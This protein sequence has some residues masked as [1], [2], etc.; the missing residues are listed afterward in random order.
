MNANDFKGGRI[1]SRH[2]LRALSLAALL[3]LAASSAWA[4]SD[5]RKGTGGA[6]ELLL[7]VGPR[8]SAL[9]S[10]ITSDVTGVDAIFWN[11]AGLAGLEGSEALF[12]HTQYIADMKVNYAAVAARAGGLGVIGFNAKVLS[13]GEIIVTTEE[14][15][16][17][18]GEIIEPTFT[19]LGLSWAK[20]F[21]D[22]VNFGGTVN[23]VNERVLSVSAT[24]V[25]MDLGVQY[26]TGW[27]G[28][29]LG[30]VMKNFG[31]T[32]EFGGD[33]LEVNTLPP[34][35]DPSAANRTLS[36][37]TAPFEMPSFFTLAATY[38]LYQRADNRL[39]MLGAFQ[40]NNFVGD[41]YIAGAEWNYRDLFALRGSWF[42]TVT[43]ELDGLTG[44]E[45]L[46]FET[47]DDL[48]SGYAFG[49][50]AKVRTGSTHL[51]V[52]V[53]YRP[54]RNFFDDTVE[55]GLKLKF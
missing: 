2:I 33:N 43:S 16:D 48:Y 49:A 22:R 27:R 14:A 29:K 34:G 42:G 9:G 39:Q 28:L 1:M 37:S 3:A 25:A 52:D 7:Q 38:N 54:V 46:S 45:S 6:T 50:G 10:G 18:T 5:E 35:S 44:D 4:G 30:M 8:G 11:P 24:G 17:G 31:G 23:I 26:D 55:V 36:F 12:S 51:S 40:N 41:S 19:V 53:A 20:Q 21:T 47:G 15:P 32:M 13:I